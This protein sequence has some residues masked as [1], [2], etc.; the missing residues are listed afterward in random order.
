MS[1]RISGT[2][3]LLVALA[4]GLAPPG[5][6]A[7][8]KR[9]GTLTFGALEA[10]PAEEAQA[11]AEAW[12]KQIGKNDPA[13][14]AQCRRLWAQSERSVLDRVAQTLALGDEQAR[15]LLAEAAD[16]E[17]PAPTEVPALLK[18]EK[19]PRFYRANLTL[20]YARLL[21][22]RRVHEEA[23]AALRLIRP[24]DVVEPATY[25]FHRAVCEHALLQKAEATRT[26]TRLLEETSEVPERYR[27]LAALLLLDMQTWKSKDLGDVARKMNNVERRLE[28]ARGGPETQ[29]LQKEIVFRLDEI[30]KDLENKLKSDCGS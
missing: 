9:G 19:L 4:L 3:A 20:A 11:Q 30:I 1:W 27:T 7:A 22:N 29:K 8:G 24:E 6:Q 15:R 12:L 25:L 26:L 2:S 14:L 28:L 18:N 21:S 16:P 10:V 23:L 13:T 5:A 17:A